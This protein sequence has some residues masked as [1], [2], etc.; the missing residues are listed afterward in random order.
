MYKI[1]YTIA[2][3]LFHISLNCFDKIWM[4]G[5]DSDKKG[6]ETLR[7]AKLSCVDIT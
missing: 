6:R 2:M 1:R 4:L 3:F 7:L 5:S